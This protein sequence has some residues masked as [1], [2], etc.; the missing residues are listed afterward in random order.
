MYRYEFRV[1]VDNISS[2]YLNTGSMANNILSSIGVLI[3]LTEQ[4]CS[5]GTFITHIFR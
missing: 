2:P 3:H 4:P 1:R 5:M